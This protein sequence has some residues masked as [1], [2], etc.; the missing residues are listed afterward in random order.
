MKKLKNLSNIVITLLILAISSF[1]NQVRADDPSDFKTFPITVVLDAKTYAGF[2]LSDLEYDRY[3]RLDIEY[4][5][6]LE[7]YNILLD[8]KNF[9]EPKFDEIQKKID[10]SFFKIEKLA[11]K[12]ESWFDRNKSWIFLT[13]GIII[14]SIGTYLIYSGASN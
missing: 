6:L 9:L 8:Y 11:F 4:N 1:N 5:S 14:G 13:G 7:K 12:T 3:T 2:L 10:D